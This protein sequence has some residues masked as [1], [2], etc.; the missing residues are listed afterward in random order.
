M[1]ISPVGFAAG[2][3]SGKDPFTTDMNVPG[4]LT[5]GHL[6]ENNHH[7]GNVI[8]A[9]PNPLSELNGAAA[10]QQLG[11]RDFMYQ[12]GDFA[13]TNASRLPPTVHVGQSLT[14]V[15]YDATQD[16]FHTI[17]ACQAPCNGV[18][19]IAYPLANGPYDFDSGELG[20]GPPGF[21]PAAN[22][23][24]WSTPSNLPPGTYTYFCRV[25][26]FMRGSFRVVQ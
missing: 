13:R 4:I 11:I 25:H 2:D 26:P 1:A 5:H 22:T 12:L 23:N 17:T 6:P 19:G 10:P 18:P 8:P 9:A 7:G 14:F 20:Y 24:T 3:L 15:N 21:T 16:I